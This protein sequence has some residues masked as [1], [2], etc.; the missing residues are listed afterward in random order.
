MGDPPDAGQWPLADC[1]QVLANTARAQPDALAVVDVGSGALHSYASLHARAAALAAFLASQGVGRGDR[2]AVASRNSLGVMEAHFAAAALHAVVV[3][4]NVH[5]A[6]PEMAYI[7]ENSD[8]AA[9]VADTSLASSLL[10]ALNAVQADSGGG[11]SVP[12]APLLWL[13]VEGGQAGEQALASAVLPS[14]IEVSE[15]LNCVVGS[16]HYLT[17]VSEGEILAVTA[18]RGRLVLPLASFADI[19]DTLPYLQAFDYASVIDSLLDIGLETVAGLGLDRENA[20]EDNFHL[21][22]TS[23]TTGKPKGVMLSQ[24]IV[25]QHALGT[26]QGEARQRRW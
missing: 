20:G 10:T 21:Y 23:G 25:L 22:Y 14:G 8:P 24:R 11:L 16:Q 4:I 26:I 7:L 1:W 3:N 18:A 6:P 15:R 9:I 5:L 2:V 13:D 12:S 19:Y 17:L